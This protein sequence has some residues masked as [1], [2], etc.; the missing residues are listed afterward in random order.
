MKKLFSIVLFG[1][2]FIPSIV[3]AEPKSVNTFEELKS[4]ITSGENEINI[5]SD[6]L[7]TDNLTISSNVVINGNSHTISRDQNYLKGLFTINETGN[8]EIKNLTIDGK[9]PG[10]TMDYDNRYYTGANNTGYVRVPTINTS[11][12]LVATA[13]LITNSGSFKLDNST[14]TNVLSSASGAVLKGTGNNAILNSSIIHTGSKTTTGS[15]YLTGGTLDISNSKFIGNVGGVSSTTG[16]KIGAIYA[17]NLTTLTIRNNTLFEDNFAQGDGGALSISKSNVT[18]SDTIFRHN[19]CGNDGSSIEFSSNVAGYTVLI[20][21]T[22]FENNY[23]FATTGQS[24][25]TILLRQWVNTKENPIVLKNNIF[26]DNKVGAGAAIADIANGGKTNVYMENIEIYGNQ[27]GGGVVAYVQYANYEVKGLNIH[28]NSLVSGGSFYIVGAVDV[29]IED[30]TI[31]NNTTSGVGGGF[32]MGAGNVNIKNSEISNN[33]ST[34]NAGGGI[35]VRGSRVGSNPN[36]TIENTTIKNNK[37][38]GIGGGISVLDNQNVFSKITIDDKS[39]IYDNISETAAD[40]FSYVRTNNSDN[41]TDNTI[42]LDNIS[43]A[44]IIGIDGWYNDNENDRFKDTENPTVFTDYI[45]NDG[46][47]AFYLKAAGISTVTYDGNGGSTS[48]KP[49]NIKYG[50]T[51][52]VDNDFPTRAGYIFTGW[53]TKE[54]GTGISLKAGDT[55]D[56]SDG[57]ILYAIWAK[58]TSNPQTG[59]NIIINVMTLFLSL[60]G[61]AGGLIYYKKVKKNNQ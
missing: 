5:E 2:I 35:Y 11:G 44:G 42:S 49:I 8:L 29:T 33:T 31:N 4:A 47:S 40:D 58:D 1:L 46:K 15:F 18:I 22:I 34:D 24:M 55:Y 14:I 54:D 39:K 12:D 37:A 51:Y 17:A 23:G 41:P 6:F 32:Y 60:L 21:N 20:E 43:I 56:G 26:R 25:G 48:A 19:M 30:A 16:V 38:K 36:L 10:W 53:N 3:N 7:F 50:Q 59:D 9:A 13:T 45:N 27:L 61:F 28:D 57:Y 52:T